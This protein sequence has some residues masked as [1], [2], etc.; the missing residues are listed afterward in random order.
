MTVRPGYPI[1]FKTVPAPP[2]S[3]LKVEWLRK[4]Y[5]NLKKN[6]VN[7]VVSE[8]IYSRML[9]WAIQDTA[10]RGTF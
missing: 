8:T 4:G 2:I 6:A 7:S 5:L 3:T 9:K 10:I 1:P